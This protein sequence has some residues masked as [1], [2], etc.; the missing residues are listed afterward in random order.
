MEEKENKKAE[1]AK[2]PKAVRFKKDEMDAI[3]KAIDVRLS[4]FIK[5]GKYK[6]VL[7]TMG[8]LSNYSLTNQIYIL[9]QRPEAR[10]VNGMKRWNLLGRHVKT[11]EKSLR[12]FSPILDFEDEEVMGDD[13]KP[14]L[15]EAGNP[16]KKTVSKVTGY[17]KAYV[18]DLSQTDGKPLDVFKFDETKSVDDKDA[19][20]KG[21]EEAVAAKGYSASYASKDELGEGCYGSCNRSTHEI[22]ILG[23]M[24]D[25]QTVST[26]VHEA[27]HALAHTD[28]RADFDGLTPDE[29]REIKEVEAESIACAVCSHLGLDTEN[30]NFSYITGW[31]DGDI[32][33]LRKNMDVIAKHASTI[34]R[35]ED[36]QLLSSNVKKAKSKTASESMEKDDGLP[37]PDP[38]DR[39]R[40]EPSSKPA[41]KVVPIPSKSGEMEAS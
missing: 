41:I 21:I 19:I 26:M 16:L 17:K 34:C 8:T 30:F 4:D 14:K 24:G 38:G 32:T 25:L 18:F 27:G 13:G 36:K 6:E 20:I 29:K 33:K 2:A 22:K 28:Y 23:G 7:L 37:G 3:M 35:Y 39:A 40:G 31:A 5:D 15:D 11:G 12:I 9:L 10:T 1:S